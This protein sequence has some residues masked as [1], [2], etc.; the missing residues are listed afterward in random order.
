MTNSNL[1]GQLDRLQIN[2]L[3][4]DLFDKFA[5][6]N[7]IVQIFYVSVL[8]STC[9]RL[10]S[11]TLTC[12]YNC[13]AVGEVFSTKT[14]SPVAHSSGLNQLWN[15]TQVQAVS[16]GVSMISY[17][18][19]ITISSSS[20]FPQA[21]VVRSEYGNN[22]F[23][24]TGNNGIKIAAAN[25]T[26]V[27][28]QSIL[29]PLPFSYGSSHTET[30]ITTYLSGADTIKTTTTKK[31]D[32]VGTGTLMLPTGTYKDVLRISGQIVE[33]QTKNGIP[34]SNVITNNINYYYS[35]KISH[36]LLYSENKQETGPRDYFPFT[37]F[38]SAIATGIDNLSNENSITITLMPNPS[39][40]ICWLA[41]SRNESGQITIT[42]A[43]GI[44]VLKQNYSGET[45]E[46]DLGELP[47]GLYTLQLIQGT[48]I[49]TKKLLIS[50]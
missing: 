9:I 12:K 50:H 31:L 21:N 29:L 40:T 41:A 5:I 30:I 18:D 37:Q 24:N 36:P 45:M 38:V 25:N 1:A 3:M 17:V 20:L 8:I 15:F 14:S 28:G 11:Q 44:I 49:Q 26:T 34:E 16:T 35:E 19:P 42:N 39:S 32:G 43:I 22:L 13:P 7:K 33:S 2:F 23:L 46:L 10:N 4:E 27:S 6:M 47:N 48:R